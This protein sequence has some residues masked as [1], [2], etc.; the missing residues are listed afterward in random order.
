M[1]Y[2]LLVSMLSSILM[3]VAVYAKQPQTSIHVIA[4]FDGKAMFSINGKKPKIIKQ[5]NT[6]EGITLLSSTTKQAKVEMDGKTQILT[7]NG[8][9]VLQSGLGSSVPASSKTSV[10]LWADERGFFVGNGSINGRSVDFLVDTGANMVALSSDQ[11]NR[12][13]L[14]YKDGV[15]TYATTAS[16]TAPMYLV[17]LDRISLKGIELNNINAGVI[18]GSYPVIP[19]LGM[20]FLSRLNMERKGNM[21]T[22]EKQ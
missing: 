3:C 18:E 22:L 11:A 1:L 8:T 19:L 15:R 13:G 14:N 21:M 6:Y 16:G 4:L 7:L 9:A 20:T 2:K 5:G 17:E 10:Q 12:I